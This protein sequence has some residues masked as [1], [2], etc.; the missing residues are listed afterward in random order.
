MVRILPFEYCMCE[1]GLLAAGRQNHLLRWIEACFPPPKKNILA[2]HPKQRCQEAQGPCNAVSTAWV[3]NRR[4]PCLRNCHSSGL[5]TCKSSRFCL[6]FRWS[7]SFI[8]LST[9]FPMSA[10]QCWLFS[11][12]F[13]RPGVWV[14]PTDFPPRR[15]I[16]CE[17]IDNSV[18]R[19]RSHK[20]EVYEGEAKEEHG[21]SVQNSK[22]RNA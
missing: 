6:F 4:H 18:K 15:Q 5:G 2:A 19:R 17:E 13:R 10:F 21:F 20:F 14:F 7:I 12:L 8:F 9:V 11:G 1:H 16:W 3:K 22:S